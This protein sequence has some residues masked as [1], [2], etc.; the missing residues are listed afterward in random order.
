MSVPMKEMVV[1]DKVRVWKMKRIDTMKSYVS[2]P[3]G[4]AEL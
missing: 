3:W 2:T 1:V 4:L